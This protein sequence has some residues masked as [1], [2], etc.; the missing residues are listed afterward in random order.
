M[1]GGRVARPTPLRYI[2][3]VAESAPSRYAPY[4]LILADDDDLSREGLLRLVDWQAAG[5]RVAAVCA[6]G[7]E[8]LDR[9]MDGGIDAVITDIKMPLVDGIE[10]ARRIGERGLDVEVLL[11]SAYRDF[12]YARSAVRYR[13]LNYLLKPFSRA[14]MDEALRELKA[15][16][17]GKG[18]VR[19]EAP[20]A[21]ARE[22]EAVGWDA[23]AAVDEAER[24]ESGSVLQEAKRFIEG[25][26]EGEVG[27]ERVAEHV[28]L[29]PIYFSRLFKERTGCTFIS[30]VTEAKIR[31][32][33]RLLADPDRRVYEIC[34]LLGYRDVNHFCQLFKSRVGCTPSEYRGRQRVG[35]GE[36]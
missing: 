34:A 31:Y 35:S 15:R 21:A 18:A 1:K 13:A 16:L 26:L 25:N 7:A 30:Y 20:Q 32:A 9:L 11:V 36:A 33:R 19:M 3:V 6:D 24:D 8:V 10:V 27:L 12:E 14:D 17:D 28:H 5:F 29:S 4:R 2:A 23:G 22:P